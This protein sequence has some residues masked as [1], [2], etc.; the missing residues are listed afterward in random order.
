MVF[1]HSG[2]LLEPERTMAAVLSS[3]VSAPSADRHDS[4]D[5]IPPIDGLRR[6]V[7]AQE[8]GFVDGR[9]HDGFEFRGIGVLGEQ[10]DAD[11]A[12]IDTRLGHVEAGVLEALS[13]RSR[14]F[15]HA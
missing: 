5:G 1:P 14:W 15:L 13:K 6:D 7:H 9:P 8:V 3:D 10:D 11:L 2:G 4:P 12:A